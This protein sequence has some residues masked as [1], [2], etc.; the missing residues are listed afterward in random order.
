M[1]PFSAKSRRASCEM[2]AL[3]EALRHLHTEGALISEGLKWL[4]HITAWQAT[5]RAL[6]SLHHRRTDAASFKEHAASVSLGQSAGELVRRRASMTSTMRPMPCGGSLS[7]SA[8]VGQEP[9]DQGRVRAGVSGSIQH[10]STARHR[11]S[12]GE[13]VASGAAGSAQ[14]EA[15]LLEHKGRGVS[16]ITVLDQV[17]K[18]STVIR[19][20]CYYGALPAAERPF[21]SFAAI[22]CRW[23]GCYAVGCVV[24]IYVYSLLG[25]RQILE[26][27]R[28]SSMQVLSLC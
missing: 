15:L 8:E 7:I 25:T 1:V 19:R 13:A 11:M 6:L 4:W 20:R 3:Y 24:V 22:W 9:T 21:P 10:R 16:V 23:A 14:S 27:L 12:L 5:A 28:G 26:G 2:R 18:S 17:R